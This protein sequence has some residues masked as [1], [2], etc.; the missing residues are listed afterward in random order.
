MKITKSQLKQIIKEELQ[1]VLSERETEE[2]YRHRIE[3]EA[4][5]IFCMYVSDDHEH[6]GQRDRNA[7]EEHA[8]Y[9]ITIINRDFPDKIWTAEELADKIDAY[10]GDD[11]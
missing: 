2:E 5:D 4:V 10:H 11:A 8:E 7:C 6:E 1:N 3:G 9:L